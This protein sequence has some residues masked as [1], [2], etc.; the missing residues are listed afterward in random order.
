VIPV[1]SEDGKANALDIL[2]YW[3]GHKEEWPALTGVC[4]ALVKRE[5]LCFLLGGGGGGEGNKTYFAMG[6]QNKVSTLSRTFPRLS[7]PV[8]TRDGLVLFFMI[9]QKI[10][11]GKMRYSNLSNNMMIS[12]L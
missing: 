4:T 8:A 12:E 9:T 2:R 7:R 11:R 3:Y 5:G 10:I 1:R 6:A